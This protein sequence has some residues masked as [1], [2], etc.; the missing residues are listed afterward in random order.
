MATRTNTILTLLAGTP[1]TIDPADTYEFGADLTISGSKNLVVS[2]NL[3]VQGTTTTVDSQTVLA[4]DNHF[5]MNAG[6]TAVAAQTGGLVINY[7]PTATATTVAAGGFTAGVAGVSNPTVATVGAATFA[8]GDLIQVSGATN[9][10]NNGL[11]EVLSHVGNTLTIRG[12]G[13]TATVEDFTQ[14]QFVTSAGAAG[15]ITKVTVSVIRAG[16]DGNWEVG[17]GSA[18]PVAFTDLAVGATS[19]QT[20]YENGNTITTSAAEGNV[21]INGDQDLVVGGSVD[22]QVNTTGSFSLDSDVASSLNVTNANLTISTT[23]GGTLALSGAA[24]VDIDAATALQVN[25]SGG[26]IQIGND[27]VNQGIDIGTDGARTI[28]VGSSGAGDTTALNLDSAG[29]MS[30]DSKDTTNLTMSASAAGAKTMTISAT[31]AGAGTGNLAL[32]ADD[33]VTIDSTAAGFSIDGVAASNVSVTS[34]ALTISTITAGLLT[35]VSAGAMDVDAATALQINSSGGVIQIG[36]DAVNQGIDIGTDGARTIQVGSSGAGDTTALNLDSAGTMSLDSK[37]TTNL[38]MA[39]T[40]GGAKT[41]TISATNAG[42]GTGNLALV[43]DDALTLDSTAAGFSI[44]GV[45]ASNVSVTTGGAAARDLTVSV[46]GGGDS[47][48]V[49]ESSGVGTDALTLRSLSG[50]M[51]FDVKPGGIGLEVKEG[52]TVTL[53]LDTLQDSWDFGYFIN[54]TTKGVGFEVNS[55]AALALGEVVYLTTSGTAQKALATTATPN[56][57]RPIGVVQAGVGGAA[58]ATKIADRGLVPVK[59]SAAPAAADNGKPVYLSSTTSGE[60]TLTAP[61][62]SGTSVVRIGQLQGA[63][64]VTTTPSVAL[65]VQHVSDT[66]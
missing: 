36:N 11:F 48:L 47:S 18:T 28:Q 3:T 49:L 43:A 35:L 7:L 13:L 2:G 60:V 24:A 29:T 9:P 19:L 64:G 66:P 38:T 62:A 50:Q 4:A 22:F 39:A 52:A 23:T 65:N 14:N 34:A 37:D 42:A 6:Y 31:N 30:L 44:D 8:T 51:L 59:F 5:Y 41:M 27:A 45:T 20:A 46:L 61:S 21:T 26:A 53:T 1:T 63:D 40:A 32:L 54:T 16:T 58:V 15:T 17:K 33:A 56:T 55:A 12:I 10:G 25:S 57:N